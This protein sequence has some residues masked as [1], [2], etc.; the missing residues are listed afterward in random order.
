MQSIKKLLKNVYDEL[1]KKV[2]AIDSSKLAEKRDYDAKIGDIAVRI[3]NII[4][5]VAK[6][7]LSAVENKTP[8]VSDLVKKQIMI[9]K[10][11]KLTKNILLL[12]IIINLQMIYLF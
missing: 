10:Y 2:N 1:I 3:F 12:L 4:G 6:A 11:Q 8:N 9:Q 7:A 5:L